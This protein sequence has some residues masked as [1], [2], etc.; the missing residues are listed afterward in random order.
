M[1]LELLIK[2]LLNNLDK[3]FEKN[4]LDHYI[5]N[6]YILISQIND[7]IKNNINISKKKDIYD[8]Y[9][10]LNNHKL[11]F[12]ST[13]YELNKFVHTLSLTNESKDNL[14]TLTSKLNN[15]NS[16]LNEKDESFELSNF[17]DL[18]EKIIA[19]SLIEIKNNYIILNNLID[20]ND[21]TEVLSPA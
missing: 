8:N 12:V 4:K 16:I 20:I 7:T 9:K 13:I 18:N 19:S 17:K 1:F 11:L 6:V 2:D 15:V 21:N 10:I 5:N 14:R 3:L